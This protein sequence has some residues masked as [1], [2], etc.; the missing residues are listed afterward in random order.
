MDNVVTTTA[1]ADNSGSLS[2]DD[3]MVVLAAHAAAEALSENDKA[4]TTIGGHTHQQA[5]S[6]HV[7]GVQEA[8]AVCLICGQ[9]GSKDPRATAASAATPKAADTRPILRF[10]PVHHDPNAALAAP[11]VTTFRQDICLH[12]FCGKTASILPHVQRPDL[13]ILTK[14]GL[15][16]KHGIGP[17]VNAALA[18]TR[19]AI[20]VQHDGS[21]SSSS[22]S[23]KEKSY[24][25]VREFEA[26]LASI[27]HT[28]LAFDPFPNTAVRMGNAAGMPRLSAGVA[29]EAPGDVGNGE[30]PAVLDEDEAVRLAAAAT[31]Q[32]VVPSS[33]DDGAVLPLPSYYEADF[34]AALQGQSS[35]TS[36]PAITPGGRSS[37]RSRSSSSSRKR[38]A[39][40]HGSDHSSHLLHHADDDDDNPQIS[41]LS[42]PHEEEPADEEVLA[43]GRV[44]CGCGGTHWPTTTARGMHSWR[45][46]ATSKR[47]QKWMEDQGLLGTVL[48]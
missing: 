46:H 28:H 31:E 33:P 1:T 44:R 30:T 6:A 37:S 27:R 13:E 5:A 2:D 39:A 41:L 15:K 24:Y 40:N 14:A 42:S 21:T 25:L 34:V 43:D 32:G 4:V 3:Q 26:H 12:I 10:L 29:S 16:N 19:C 7:N 9:G 17:E 45:S 11:G 38:K 18:R 20:V 23:S 36:A 8:P 35:T 48:L 47:H 22:S